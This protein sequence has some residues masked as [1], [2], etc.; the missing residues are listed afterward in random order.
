[1]EENYVTVTRCIYLVARK[2]AAVARE[3]KLSFSATRYASSVFLK[4]VMERKCAENYN[5]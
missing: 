2:T 4:K 3:L 1:M 5:K